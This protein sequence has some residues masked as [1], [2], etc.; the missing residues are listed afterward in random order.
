MRRELHSVLYGSQVI[1]FQLKRRKRTTL[2]ISVYPDLTVEVVAP[3]D[4][5][6]ERVYAKVRARARWIKHQLRF[7]DQFLPRTPDRQ[8]V[9]GETHRYL[10]RQYRLKVVEGDSPSVKL[11]RGW[12]TVTSPAPT[13][14]AVTRRLVEAWFLGRARGKFAERLNEC[15]RLFP[16]PEAVRPVGLIVRSLSARWGSMTAARRLVLNR[17]LIQAPTPCIDYVIAHELCHVLHPH[18]GPEFRRMLEFVMPDWEKRKLRL[19]Q[20]MA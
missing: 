9:S 16:D 13:D 10:G 12:L 11:T 7:F 20:V 19:E 15:L 18:H 1:S 14:V 2:A 6:L 17:R 5:P 8:Y 3:L 4:A